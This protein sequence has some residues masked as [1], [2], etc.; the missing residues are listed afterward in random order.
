MSTATPDVRAAQKPLRA[1]YAEH[2]EDALDPKWARTDSTRFHP[3]DPYNGV[4]E[5]GRGYGS[6]FRYGIDRYVGG[7]GEHP[8][9][10]DLICAGLA[11][12]VDGAIR[13]VA[14]VMG[15]EL[16]SLAV[17][18]RGD[19]DVRGTLLMDPAV[20]V[21]FMGMHIGIELEPAAGVDPAQ[22]TTLVDISEKVCVSLATLRSEVKVTTEVIRM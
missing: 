10:P 16:V 21:G 22:V 14:N 17:E 4:V 12:C 9:P 11:G 2:P 13:M 3:S 15:I 20:P 19:V 6:T 5:V 18:V 8:T 1:R 7:P